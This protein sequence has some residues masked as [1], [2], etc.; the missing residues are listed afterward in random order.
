MGK[1]IVKLFA[2]VIE[3]IFKHVTFWIKSLNI[4]SDAVRDTLFL[5]VSCHNHQSSNVSGEILLIQSP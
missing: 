5:V 4:L 2:S 3:D 1:L